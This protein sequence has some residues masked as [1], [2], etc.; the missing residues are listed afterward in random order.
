MVIADGETIDRVHV[1]L[2][3]G[4]GGLE[5]GAVTND[6][7]AEKDV[8]LETAVLVEKYLSELGFEVL[9]T[10]YTDIRIPLRT[11]A[12]IADSLEASLLVSIH[13]QGT[14]TNIPR[15][16]I[17]GT[18]VYYQQTNVESKRF[19]GLLIEEARAEFAQF[20]IEWFAGV[21]AGATYRPNA[22][23]GEDF[24]GMVRI[25]ETPAVLAEMAFMGNP[26]EVALLE[27]GE[28][29]EASAQAITRSIVRWFTTDD[30]GVG[31]VEPSFGLRSSGGGGGLEG[32][33]DPELEQTAEGSES[34]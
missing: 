11:R 16:E 27:S 23:T 30:P 3:P 33:T 2:D 10:R 21:D 22:V 29:Q 31:F 5:P 32:C 15:S 9:L 8:N 4:H 19:A 26:A 20:P 24:F 14:E 18:E 7:L 34:Q 13:H 1:V 6:G 25:P 17:P 12:Q 28:L